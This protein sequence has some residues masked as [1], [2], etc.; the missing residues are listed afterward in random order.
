MGASDLAGFINIFIPL[1][2][3]AVGVV[4][5]FW[6]GWTE[7]TALRSS[8][9]SL[10]GNESTVIAHPG[11]RTPSGAVTVDYAIVSVYGVF[12]VVVSD[13][14]GRVTG[15][16]DEPRWQL[17]T[18]LHTVE[19]ENPLQRTQAFADALRQALPAYRYADP[20]AIVAYPV[21]DVL[22]VRATQ[23]VTY[24]SKVMDIIASYDVPVLSF[25]QAT[26]MGYALR[27]ADV[28]NG[29]AAAVLS[30]MMG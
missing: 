28:N 4:L 21:R 8:L 24:I 25:S 7:R 6:R 26:G 30:D 27:H 11:L 10:S 3:V 18:R 5:Y 29:E 16:E 1:L 20:V 2:M 17:R 19:A 14:K 22:D 12:L 13:F 9:N 15:E 23:H